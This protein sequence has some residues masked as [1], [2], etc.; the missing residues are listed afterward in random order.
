MCTSQQTNYI[1]YSFGSLLASHTAIHYTI[2]NLVLVGSP[3]Q[4]IF[5]Y[6]LINELS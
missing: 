5:V 6:N 4:G 3:I 1:G 2:D